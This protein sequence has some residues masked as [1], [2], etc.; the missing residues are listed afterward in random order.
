M[1]AKTGTRE[2]LQSV[3][4]NQQKGNTLLFQAQSQ[5]HQ[6]SLKMDE[7]NARTDQAAKIQNEQLKILTLTELDRQKQKAMKNKVF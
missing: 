4:K 7:L 6:M 3:E 5:L 1:P 2:I